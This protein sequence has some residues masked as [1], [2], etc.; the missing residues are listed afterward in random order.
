MS[1]FSPHIKSKT[2]KEVKVSRDE[3]LDFDNA[4]SVSGSDY[5][6]FGSTNKDSNSNSNKCNFKMMEDDFMKKDFLEDLDLNLINNI[7]L[8]DD[9]D[10]QEEDENNFEEELKK[11]AEEVEGVLKKKLSNHNVE[12]MKTHSFQSTK[13]LKHN[14]FM[15]D[16]DVKKIEEEIRFDLGNN[17]EYVLDD[18]EQYYIRKSLKEQQKAG[19]KPVRFKTCGN[20]NKNPLKNLDSLNDNSDEDSDNEEKKNINI[21]RQNVS[22]PRKNVKFSVKK[23]IFEYPEGDNLPDILTKEDEE[24]GVNS[25]K[26]AKKKKKVLN[27]D[28]ELSE[29]ELKR[30]E[31]V[32]KKREEQR[33]AKEIENEEKKKKQEELEALKQETN[34]SNTS[35][36]S[37]GSKN[38]KGGGKKKGKKKH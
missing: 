24:N 4:D 3:D 6:S 27:D 21:N 7:D 17:S 18:S 11:Q 38:S 5:E 16:D 34:K 33:I 25:N 14:I 37:K 8:V 23:V 15:L 31:E 30:L 2:T 12:K 35:F 28:D 19:F 36:T 9:D 13:V 26:K 1:K 29:A 32:R 10:K 22:P 20:I